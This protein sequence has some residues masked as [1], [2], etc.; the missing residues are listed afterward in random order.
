MIHR[1][2][3]TSFVALALLFGLCGQAFAEEK[4]TRYFELQPQLGYSW[5]NLSGFSQ[6]QFLEDV[7]GNLQPSLESGEVPVEGFGPSA[8]LGAQLKLWVFVLG[9]RYNYTTTSDFD[10]HT[11][12]VDLGLRLGDEVALYGRAGLGLAFLSSLPSELTTDG[13]TLPAS[14]GLD[15]KLSE[16]VSLGLGLDVEVL[17]LTQAQ[18]LQSAA[19]MQLQPQE[20]DRDSIGFQ[21]RPQLHLTWHL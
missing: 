7:E 4:R 2:L 5:V 12:A 10:V 15:F 16:A 21:L 11:V 20:I 9:T 6:E 19:T 18:K 14:G 13:F 8:G 17:L 3:L 1:V